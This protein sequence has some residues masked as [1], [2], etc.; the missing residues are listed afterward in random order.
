MF[1]REIYLENQNS[2]IQSNYADIIMLIEEKGFSIMQILNQ[3]QEQINLCEHVINS[4]EPRTVSVQGEQ[5]IESETIT[6]TSALGYR[7]QAMF[8]IVGTII[9]AEEND[10]VER[11]PNEIYQSV[12]E[13][14]KEDFKSRVG[15]IEL[16]APE[17]TEEPSKE[18]I[19]DLEKPIDGEKIIYKGW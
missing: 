12:S 1:N 4:G 10:I 15:L 9:Y 14:I 19:L 17:E 8:L 11:I 6:P 13:D 7:A 18:A 2:I 16:D 3:I 5:G